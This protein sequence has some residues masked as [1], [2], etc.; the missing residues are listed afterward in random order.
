LK[1]NRNKDITVSTDT[2]CVT[3]NSDVPS[4]CVFSDLANLCPY[5]LQNIGIKAKKIEKSCYFSPKKP[6]LTLLIKLRFT[7]L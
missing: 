7:A 2:K 3:A 4:Y 6:A 1:Q 5:F